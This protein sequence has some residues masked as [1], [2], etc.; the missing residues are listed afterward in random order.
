[1]QYMVSC[2]LIFIKYGMSFDKYIVGIFLGKLRK[3]VLLLFNLK[4][5]IYEHEI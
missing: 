2:F 1:M 3:D 4:T 5:K